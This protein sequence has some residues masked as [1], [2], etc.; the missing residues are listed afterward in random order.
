MS[1]HRCLTSS[2]DAS[3][4]NDRDSP[5]PDLRTSL[6]NTNKHLV[7]YNFHDLLIHFVCKNRAAERRAREKLPA[8]LLA[9][10]QS[11]SCALVHQTTQQR[12]IKNKNN[13]GFF[14]QNK[15]EKRRRRSALFLRFNLNVCFRLELH[16][17][18]HFAFDSQRKHLCGSSRNTKRFKMSFLDDVD[19][20]ASFPT[21]MK[22]LMD[23]Y[24]AKKILY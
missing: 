9:P 16:T 8:Q 19:D 4:A 18:M 13:I 23:R 6:R 21:P 2:F 24:V 10:V 1:T 3:T 22:H 15:R 7:Q 12:T 17:T 20:A 11:D 14:F 5:Q